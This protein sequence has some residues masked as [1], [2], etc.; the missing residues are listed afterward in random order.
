MS[1]AGKERDLRSLWRQIAHDYDEIRRE[2]EEE[3]ASLSMEER[4]WLTEQL[5]LFLRFGDSLDT[6][7]LE[8]QIGLLA[9]EAG[10][11]ELME[12]WSSIRGGGP[13]G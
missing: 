8:K 1:N 7:Y 11:P 5:L 13:D 2:Q 9:Q 12:R 4:I 6:A 10:L 3:W